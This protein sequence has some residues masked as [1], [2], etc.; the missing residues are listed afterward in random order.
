VIPEGPPGPLEP[1]ADGEAV[2]QK[3]NGANG[4]HQPAE[5]E[6]AA[7]PEPTPAPGPAPTTP[8]DGRAANG[9]FAKG[10]KGGPGNPFARK[11]AKLRSVLLDAVDPECLKRIASK[12]IELAE[13]C[14]D[15]AA[16]KL[17]FSYC[18]GQPG[19]AVSPDELD[20]DEWRL[21]DSKPTKS[22]VLRA[23]LDS[24]DPAEAAA[25]LE[26]MIHTA[27]DKV[28]KEKLVAGD[29]KRVDAERDARIGQR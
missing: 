17:L 26:T 2:P 6:K 3:I 11:V 27:H 23:M 29:A 15:L 10:N 4:H 14:G 28:L 1:F 9:T 25:L 12:L 22:A 16:M 21:A 24:V 20:L 18:L 19:L 13:L 8:Q 5:A 7:T